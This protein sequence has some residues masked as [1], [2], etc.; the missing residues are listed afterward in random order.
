MYVEVIVCNVSVVFLTHSE[1]NCFI[2][3]QF[4]CYICI[5]FPHSCRRLSWCQCDEIRRP[6]IIFRLDTSCEF[7][8]SSARTCAW[9]WASSPRVHLCRWT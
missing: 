6:V 4:L 8:R 2:T 7:A 1:I 5:W 3:V 9:P